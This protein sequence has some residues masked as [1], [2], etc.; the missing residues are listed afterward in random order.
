M[1]TTLQGLHLTHRHVVHPTDFSPWGE[2]AFRHAVKL[3][4]LA[5]SHL[6]LLH[7]DPDA[8]ATDF[9]DFPRV[10]PL[11]ARW[12]LLP[13]D[14][15]TERVQELGLY[16]QKIRAAAPQPAQAIVHHVAAHPADMVVLASHR[17]EAI[18]RWLR[19][20][21]AE[22]IARGAHTPT[23]FVPGDQEGFVSAADGALRLRRV[24]LPA[25]RADTA[26]VA[27]D[28]IDRLGTLLACERLVIH[29][30]H[31]DDLHVSPAIRPP[32]HPGWTWEATRSRGDV[33]E[34]ILA[35]ST[36][37]Q[38]DLIVMATE[39]HTSWADVWHGSTTEQVLRQALCPVLA[40]PVS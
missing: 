5:R 26:Q 6:T 12:G 32:D 16:V 25:A 3:A 27:A 24:L 13:E 15:P 35:L 38:P 34:A 36:E 17:R 21:V 40:L 11:L 14:S 33:V 20:S 28:T 9:A 2:P 22:P 29:L 23:L 31:V 18:S 7:I 1:S 10:R 30:L 37:L 8:T 19:R 39:G 4:L